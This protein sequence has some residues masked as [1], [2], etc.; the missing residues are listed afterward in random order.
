MTKKNS[1]STS[2][3]IGRLKFEGTA[4]YWD[5]EKWDVW[6]A[7]ECVVKSYED[8]VDLM[9]GNDIDIARLYRLVR[10]SNK[11]NMVEFY[12]EKLHVHRP[13]AS[14]LDLMKII[15][16]GEKSKATYY[17]FRKKLD[18]KQII[19]EWK[20]S[21]KDGEYT[22]YF[23]NPLVTLK[24]RGIRPELYMFFKESL[25]RELGGVASAGLQLIYEIRHFRPGEQS[26]IFPANSARLMAIK[27]LM[28]DTFEMEEETHYVDDVAKWISKNVD[29]ESFLGVLAG[30]VFSDILDITDASPSS[31][32]AHTKSGDRYITFNANDAKHC[33]KSIDIIDL[34][35]NL[36]ECEKKDAVNYLQAIYN[37][38]HESARKH[39]DEQIQAA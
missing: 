31:K 17:A 38:K 10:C 18:K 4:D 20:Y 23:I 26:T 11:L 27:N 22:R 19:Y 8:F 39:E 2:N 32:V 16:V 21:D 33:G 28:T 12:D 3:K 29:M 34:V 35:M 36:A 7:K 14:M 24:D 13:A 9:D 1:F 6:R 5:G 30:S 37:V 15:N 25:D